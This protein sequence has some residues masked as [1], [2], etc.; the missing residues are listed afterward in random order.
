MK[1]LILSAVIALSFIQLQAQDRFL[2]L[3]DSA[4]YI[5][6][7]QLHHG[8]NTFYGYTTLFG[9]T[10]YGTLT[11]AD[12]LIMQ[13]P[14]VS[15][16]MSN[17]DIV[18]FAAATGQAV[19]VIT[20]TNFLSWLN[21]VYTVYFNTGTFS[22]A[23][24]SGS[25]YVLVTTPSVTSASTTPITSGGVYS[26]SIPNSNLQSQL[27]PNSIALQGTAGTGFMSFPTQSVAPATP[28]SGIHNIYTNSLGQFTVMGSNGFGWSISRASLTASRL[29]TAP[30]SSGTYALESR[31][32]P[33]NNLAN[34]GDIALWTIQQDGSP[35][36]GYVPNYLINQAPSGQ[37]LVSGTE[38]FQKITVPVNATLTGIVVEMNTPGVYTSSGD[39]RVG[40]YSENLS[41]GQLTLVASS[42]TSTTLWTS[43]SNFLEIPFSSTYT[44]TAGVYEVG[45]IYQESAQTTAPKI[46]GSTFSLNTLGFGMTSSFKMAGTLAGQTT[47]ASPVNSSSLSGSSNLYHVFV[48]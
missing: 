1:K 47:L 30:D 42:T 31:V 8:S 2:R 12:S 29:Y 11:V 18:L 9:Q 35:I 3:S 19:S 10:T 48:Y 40:L 16:S 28:A 27:Q 26:W 41:T 21:S 44:A 14:V 39:N 33:N 36:K 32:I 13:N 24:T 37:A 17:L 22:G 5:S 20:Q 45:L 6:N 7:W 4:F 23:G 34:G 46:Y 38:V 15:S 25:P 43:S